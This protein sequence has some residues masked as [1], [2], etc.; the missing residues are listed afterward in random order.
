MR[1]ANRF[2]YEAVHLNAPAFVPILISPGQD[3]GFLGREFEPLVVGDPRAADAGLPGL[4]PQSGLPVIRME[5]RQ[6]LKETLNNYREHLAQD[7]KLAD[8]SHLYQ[9]A[10]T[11]LSSPHYRDAF[12]LSQESDALRDRYGRHRSIPLPWQVRAF[13][14]EPC[15]AHRIDWARNRSRSVMDLGT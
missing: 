7:Q 2:A 11:M 5:N 9:Q 13:I 10:L 1:V 14:E 6:T 4:A 15:W 12:D 8:M 3:G